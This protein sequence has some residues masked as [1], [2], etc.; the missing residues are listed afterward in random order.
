MQPEGEQAFGG[1][2]SPSA[3]SNPSQRLLRPASQNSHSSGPSRSAAAGGQPPEGLLPFRL[4]PCERF[5]PMDL[6]LILYF[7]PLDGDAAAF[8]SAE[9]G[10]L[11]LGELVDSGGQAVVHFVV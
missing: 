2:R 3:H 7:H 5:Y 4:H 1:F 10:H 8:H 11:T 6:M 9:P